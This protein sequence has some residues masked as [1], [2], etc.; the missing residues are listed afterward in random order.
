MENITVLWDL[1]DRNV[2]F[3]KKVENLRKEASISWGLQE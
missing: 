1:G 3:C 2:Q